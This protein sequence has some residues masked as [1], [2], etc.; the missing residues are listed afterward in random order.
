[1]S[2]ASRSAPEHERAC[3]ASLFWAHD[4]ASLLCIEQSPE[5]RLLSEAGVRHTGKPVMCR[6]NMACIFSRLGFAVLG[7]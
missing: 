2:F 7:L 3:I 4:C 6:S 1:M 5:A